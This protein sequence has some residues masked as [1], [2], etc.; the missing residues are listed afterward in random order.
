[1]KMRKMSI[2]D[3]FEK[4]Q[5]KTVETDKLNI[6]G[7]LW[8]KCPSCSEVIFKKDLT[9]Q[10]MVCPHCQ[11][12][13]RISPK[14]RIDIIFDSGSFEEIDGNIVPTDF[15]KFED[16]EKYSDRINKAQ[17]KTGKKEAVIIGTATLR[18]MPVNVALMDFLLWVD[19]WGLL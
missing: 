6:P 2:L 19:Q 12:H 9:Q 18:S 3:W 15:L 10:S 14:Q 16:V 13:F 11:Y 7:D 17:K 4:K 5:K 8:V 1:M